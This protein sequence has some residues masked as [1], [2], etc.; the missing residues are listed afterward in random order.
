MTF[1]RDS[2][3]W[4]SSRIL[5]SLPGWFTWAFLLMLSFSPFTFWLGS[6][7]KLICFS[8]YVKSS[9][10]FVASLHTVKSVNIVSKFSTALHRCSSSCPFSNGVFNKVPICWSRDSSSRASEEI[11]HKIILIPASYNTSELLLQTIWR[12]CWL[13]EHLASL[14]VWIESYCPSIQAF[15]CMNPWFFPLLFPLE[16]WDGLSVLMLQH[17]HWN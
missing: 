4:F 16:S 9:R 3:C 8:Y 14:S 11:K 13:S 1:C 10:M 15:S 12:Y 2:T 7:A 17:L 6:D 5:S